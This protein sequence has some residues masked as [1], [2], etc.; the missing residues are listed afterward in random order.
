M[1]AILK[2]DLNDPDERQE[3]KRV[4]KSLELALALC[5]I[6]KMQ[7]TKKQRTQFLEI[8]DSYNINLEEI[9]S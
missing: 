5:Y 4:N 8:L 1:E 3:F 2:F 6:D 7:M 9:I